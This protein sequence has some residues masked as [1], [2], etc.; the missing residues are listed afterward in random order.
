MDLIAYALRDEYAGTVTQNIDDQDV[1]VPAYSGGVIRAG[2]ELDVNVV[3]ELEAGGGFIVIDERDTGAAVHL[4]AYPPL[5][6]VKVPEGAEPSGSF[7]ELPPYTNQGV[8][9][10]RADAASRGLEGAG[11]ARKADLVAALE[12]HDLR[13]AEDS[14]DELGAPITVA[15]L[16]EAAA[17]RTSETPDENTPPDAD[18]G[19]NDQAGRAGEEG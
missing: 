16:L 18:A 3:E 4:D 6:R 11:S 14:L 13:R 15:D 1:E 5:E 7:A 9:E 8:P 12:E 10:L 2:D 17:G 19:D